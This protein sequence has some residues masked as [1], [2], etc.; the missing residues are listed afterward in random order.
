ML[1]DLLS[2]KN[3]D[4]L[5][6]KGFS[7]IIDDDTAKECASQLKVYHQTLRQL[8]LAEGHLRPWSPCTV[9]EQPSNS[10]PIAHAEV[11]AI[12]N[13][14]LWDFYH[15]DNGT[16][17]FNFINTSVK[18]V[19]TQAIYVKSYSLPLWNKHSLQDFK[20]LIYAVCY[21]HFPSE[22]QPWIP[23]HTI[24]KEQA[25]EVYTRFQHVDPVIISGETIQ[26]RVMEEYLQWLSTKSE[27]SR[28]Q[29]LKQS[30]DQ[31]L[32]QMQFIEKT[33]DQ[34]MQPGLATIQLN[35]EDTK[36]F[37][38]EVKERRKDD[39]SLP[40]VVKDS[41]GQAWLMCPQ[42]YKGLKKFLKVSSLYHSTTNL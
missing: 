8:P 40:A 25:E 13:N 36:E 5:P 14:T 21:H 17:L 16:N 3:G 26:R 35:K 39:D 33:I 23:S 37:V 22:W 4:L 41:Q 20:T 31:K 29:R 38:D 1:Q 2:K 19:L 34:M 28:A 24:N 10:R 27:S 12:L 15:R 18:T 42:V 9:W 7:V 11:R 6:R 30:N 32:T